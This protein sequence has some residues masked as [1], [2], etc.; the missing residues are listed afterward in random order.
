MLTMQFSCITSKKKHRPNTGSVFGVI[1]PVIGA[2]LALLGRSD[3]LCS[4]G[5]TIGET[6]VDAPEASLYAKPWP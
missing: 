4:A 6:S 5:G 3:A 2:I 1:L